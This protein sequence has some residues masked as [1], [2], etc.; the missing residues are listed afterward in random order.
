MVEAIETC[1]TTERETR[2]AVERYSVGYTMDHLE[3]L[4]HNV[5][6]SRDEA[7]TEVESPWRFSEEERS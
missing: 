6:L 2:A 7:A 3:Q 4:Y 1:L 5:P